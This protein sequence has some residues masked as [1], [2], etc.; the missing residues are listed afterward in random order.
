MCEEPPFTY[1]GVDVFGP[2]GMKRGSKEL[3]RYGTLLT[4]L[5]SQ[6]TH[7]KATNSLSTFCF[8]MC[9]PRLTGQSG[10]VRLIR[11]DNGTNF[12]GPSAELT[13]SFTEMNHQKINQFMEDNGGEGMSLKRNP[14]TASNM[15]GV[16]ERQ[17]R[18][19]RKILES[20]LKA[21]RANL[22]DEFLQTQSL[23]PLSPINLL[24]MR[25]KIMMP[26]PG[27]FLAPDIYSCKHWR[28]VKHIS[29]EF[30]DQWR[31]EVP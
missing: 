26:P 28:R 13:K 9:L 25:S 4:R 8:L 23:I 17:I 31:E 1:C 21:H 14:P 20:L 24:T 22:R 19:D 5:S 2:F 15:V 3:K 11:S 29:N 18:F 12:V 6:A 16:W 10:N 7:T 30:W 27:V